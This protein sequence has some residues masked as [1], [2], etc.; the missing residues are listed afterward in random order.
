MALREGVAVRRQ[1]EGRCAS[2]RIVR[3]IEWH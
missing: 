3:E 2:V 1:A